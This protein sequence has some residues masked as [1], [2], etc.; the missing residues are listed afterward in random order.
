MTGEWALAWW[1]TG[2][3]LAQVHV[4]QLLTARLIPRANRVNSVG[5]ATAL[6]AGR[7]E[8]RISVEGEI[9]HTRTGRL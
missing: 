5:I 1:S 4:E 9:F 3:T 8:D 2:V 6:R 7:P